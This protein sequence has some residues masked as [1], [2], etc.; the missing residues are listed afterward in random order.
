M[1]FKDGDQLKEPFINNQETL[2]HQDM[3]HSVLNK[4]FKNLLTPNKFINTI[5]DQ[6]SAED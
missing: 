3:S 6:D 1:K 2:S 5:K 4:S